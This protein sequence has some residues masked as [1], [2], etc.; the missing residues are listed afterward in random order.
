MELKI[1]DKDS[2][3]EDIAGLF[4]DAYSDEPYNEKWN[5]KNAIKRIKDF[6]SKCHE[7][8]FYIEEDKKPS[9][10][11]LCQTIEWDDGLHLVIEDTAIR[12]DLRGR[13]LG[14]LFYKE[15]EKRA[16]EK[17]ISCIDIL[18]NKKNAGAMNFWKEMGFLGGAYVQMSKGIL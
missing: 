14:K 6:S 8:C 12:K 10:V 3:L 9:G 5:T 7:F 16:K 4:V 11:I 2:P 18:V 1:I 13:G 17:G 15:V